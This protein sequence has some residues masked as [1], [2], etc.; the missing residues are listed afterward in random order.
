M[1]PC[2]RGLMSTCHPG[3]PVCFAGELTLG[4]VSWTPSL[5]G[6][7]RVMN[8]LVNRLARSQMIM[9]FLC[10]SLVASLETGKPDGVLE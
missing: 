6:F 4:I 8:T 5:T 7:D 10:G 3:V 1:F 9:G 2:L